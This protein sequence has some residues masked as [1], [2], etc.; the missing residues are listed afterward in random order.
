LK[1]VNR[2][3]SFTPDVPAGIDLGKIKKWNDPRIRVSNKNALLPDSD[4][5]V[6]H[7][8]D[9]S[10]T[11][12]IWTDYLSKSNPDWKTAVGASTVIQWPVGAGAEGNDGVASMVQQTANSIGYV[13]L[14]YALRHQLNSGAV[15]NAAGEF[16][17]ADLAS[18]SAAAVGTAGTTSPDLGLSIT[19]AG[20]KGAYPIATFT[21]WLLPMDL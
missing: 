9:G 1:G 14:V 20:G 15:R 13:E 21:C 17:H 2:N 11:T 5:L 7:R 4:I 16:V 18:V 3:L 6:I 12:F 8:S 10:G 19:N